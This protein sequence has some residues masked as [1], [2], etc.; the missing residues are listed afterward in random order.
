MATGNAHCL[1]NKSFVAEN[2]KAKEELLSNE[3]MWVSANLWKKY[4]KETYNKE[5]QESEPDSDEFDPEEDYPEEEVPAWVQ[6][7][8]QPPSYIPMAEDDNTSD[9]GLD[10]ERHNAG[11]YG[12]KTLARSMM[13]MMSKNKG[14][15]IEDPTIQN[16]LDT[17]KE[18]S[19]A[20]DDN[21]NKMLKLKI[22]LLNTKHDIHRIVQVM[23]TISPSFMI[24]FRCLASCL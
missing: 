5:Y 21:K 9:D 7:Y 14:E 20:L 24:C 19:A 10:F 12:M 22:K 6:A 18:V 3:Q 2:T 16:F 13:G 8:T 17:L 4:Y 23:T 1:V 15:T 11:S